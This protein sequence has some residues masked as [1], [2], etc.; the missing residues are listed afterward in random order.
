[1]KTFFLLLFF[2][3]I[4]VASGGVLWWNINI[5]APDP[6]NKTPQIFVV[7]QGEG[8]KSIGEGLE[9]AG[10]IKNS[11]VFY[12]WVKMH[13]LDNKIQSGDFRLTPSQSLETLAQNL[14]H[15]SLDYWLRVPE[16]ERADQI[17]E[18][19]KA[20]SPNYKDAWK[21]ELEANEGYLFP[22]SYLIPMGDD[23]NN[24]ISTMRNNFDKKYETIGSSNYSQ[25][26]IVT[27]ASI[28]QREANFAEE[29]PMVASVLYNRLDIGM[30]LQVDPSISY[31]IGYYPPKK[32]W[33][34]QNLTIEDLK[35][36]SPYNTY[37]NTGL[38]PT[39]ISN[40]GLP[41]LQAAA[42]PANSDY[43]YYLS[44]KSGHLHFSKTFTG[45]N[46]NIEKYNIQ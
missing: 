8:M 14:T 23:I 11:T 24:I 41:A 35:I 19:L 30:A 26:E 5:A 29:E 13:N 37:I 9:K 6:S 44:D 17:A 42:H 20:L 25:K 40:P 46:N 21:D 18:R 15:G 33:W 16:G 12:I 43:L 31:A 3:L 22:D 39:P 36:N 32:T 7:S 27:I 34:K 10:L 38:P 1:M 2:L 4:L 28:I 45:H